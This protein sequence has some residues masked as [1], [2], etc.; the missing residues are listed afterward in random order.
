MKVELSFALGGVKNHEIYFGHLGKGT[1]GGPE[2]TLLDMINRDFGEVE[3]WQEDL[4]ASGMAARGWVWLSYD[5]DLQKLVN[6]IGDSQN[7]FL[8]WNAVPLL[9]LDTYEHAYFIDYGTDRKSYIEAFLRNLNWDV[10]S[11]NAEG[12]L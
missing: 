11:K 8:I 3:K 4:K 6:F 12:V 2:G 1:K 7:T 9:A 10:I 5:R